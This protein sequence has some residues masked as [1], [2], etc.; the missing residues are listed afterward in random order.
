MYKNCAT[1]ASAARQRQLEQG[2]LMAMTKRCYDEIT[3]SDLCAEIG[4]PRKSFYRYFSGKEGALHALIDHTIQTFEMQYVPTVISQGQSVQQ[5]ISCFF[6]FWRQ[7]KMLLD[8]LNHS[9]L[10]G[11]LIERII[12][13]SVAGQFSSDH[14]LQQVHKKLRTEAVM[15]AVCGLMS[16]VLRWHQDG[17]R[18]DPDSIAELAAAL[19]T[20]PLFS[21]T[22]MKQ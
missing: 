20:Q 13:Y 9:G 1:E 17:Y 12:N 2:L 3:V 22:I 18:A 11:V 19:L 7:Q 5:G 4:V 10:S 21:D 16:M 6:Q 8:A 15:F 14:I